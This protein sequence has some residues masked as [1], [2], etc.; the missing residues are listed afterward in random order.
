MNNIVKPLLKSLNVTNIN[1][2]PVVNIIQNYA[3]DNLN[4]LNNFDRK[5]CENNICEF[6]LPIKI[7]HPY[8]NTIE[9]LFDFI[10]KCK[11]NLQLLDNRIQFNCP[12]TFSLFLKDIHDLLNNDIKIYN[13]KQKNKYIQLKNFLENL[14]N[15]INKSLYDELFNNEQINNIYISGKKNKHPKID[16]LNKIYFIKN[17]KKLFKSDIY[18]EY[19]DETI[20]GF[21]IKQSKDATK[22]NYSLELITNNA[23]N[24]KETRMKLLN[25]YGHQKLDK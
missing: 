14:N 23:N 7:C 18:I 15:D 17:N 4:N 20:K 22:S 12:D 19:N 10:K 2:S 6:I 13:N 21:S 11:E 5:T 8:I 1:P 16:E 9:E 24:L 25:D 3:I